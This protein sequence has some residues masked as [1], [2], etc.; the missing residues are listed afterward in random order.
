MKVQEHKHSIWS[1][2]KTCTLLAS[3]ATR[4]TVLSD[5]NRK[6]DVIAAALTEP[7]CNSGLVAPG[8]HFH[9]QL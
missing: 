2:T 1:D 3:R 5:M 8:L 6:F 9:I 7:L 4:M